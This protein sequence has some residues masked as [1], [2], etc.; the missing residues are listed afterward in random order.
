[1]FVGTA[2]ESLHYIGAYDD[3]LSTLIIRAKV[4]KQLSAV[5]ALQSLVDE[6]IG[7]PDTD[8]LNTDNLNNGY[9]W[10]EHFADYHLLP[11]PIPR[12][13]LM[14]RGFNLPLLLAKRLSVTVFC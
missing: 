3:I 10:A 13:R 7:K 1:M 11:M 6:F 2:Y 14:Q 5:I 4:G 8:N 12:S 9:R